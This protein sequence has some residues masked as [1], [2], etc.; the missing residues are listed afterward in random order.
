ME[1]TMDSKLDVRLAIVRG[2]HAS[3][4][5]KNLNRLLEEGYSLRLERDTVNCSD[6]SA[7]LYTLTK[8]LARKALARG[9]AAPVVAV[10]VAAAKPRGRP[11]KVAA[12]KPVPKKVAAARDAK[13]AAA[14]TT[15]AD[16]VKAKR[17]RKPKAASGGAVNVVKA[18]RKNAGLTQAALAKKIGKTQPAVSLA[19]S[20]GSADP[21]LVEL[22]L[23]ACELPSGWQPSA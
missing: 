21:E 3:E 10:P 11:R 17:G 1:T 18:A 12:A 9:A 8:T 16:G 23:K 15:S 4:D 6:G 5:I 7:L 2:N 19:E 13:R 22:V 14:S 20:N